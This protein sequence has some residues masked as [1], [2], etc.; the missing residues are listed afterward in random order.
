MI[1]LTTLKA[2]NLLVATGFDWILFA[3][4]LVVFC[5][6]VLPWAFLLYMVKKLF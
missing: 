4:V 3:K 5:I 2:P 1:P 6:V